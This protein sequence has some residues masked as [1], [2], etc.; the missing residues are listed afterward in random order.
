MFNLE[1]SHF[2]YWSVGDYKT[3]SKL[4]ALEIHLKLNIP[5]KYHFNDEVYG[6]IDWTQE[7]VQSITDMYF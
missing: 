5:V 6:A 2:G 1:K 4:E 3:F 7:P